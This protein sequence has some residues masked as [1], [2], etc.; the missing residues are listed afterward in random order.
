MLKTSSSMYIYE[1]S[2]FETKKRREATE[3]VVTKMKRLGMWEA[4][5]EKRNEMTGAG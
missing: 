1:N 4:E 2:Q 5:A 3:K